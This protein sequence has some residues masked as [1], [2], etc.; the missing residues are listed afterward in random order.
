MICTLISNSAYALIAPFLPLEF[1]AQNISGHMIGLM[2]AIYSVAVILSSP[3]VGKSVQYVGTTNMISLGIAVMGLAFICFGFIPS[4]DDTTIILSVG[5]VLRFI[6]G[7][8]SAF[9]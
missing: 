5:F 1:K 8:S 3:F 6:Q 9:V 2:F 7:A 4:I